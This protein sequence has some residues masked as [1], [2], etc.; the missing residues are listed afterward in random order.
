MRMLTL[1]LGLAVVSFVAYRAVYGRSAVGGAETPRRALDN[2][3]TSAS[4]IEAQQEKK[5]QEALEQAAPKE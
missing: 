5:A 1:V 2:V 3:R 4:G